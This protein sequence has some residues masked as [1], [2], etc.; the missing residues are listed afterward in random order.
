MSKI[1]CALLIVQY[2]DCEDSVVGL[3]FKTKKPFSGRVYVHGMAGDEKCSR[4]FVDNRNQSRL[5]LSFKN[6]DC[7][8]Q[9]QRLSGKIQGLLSSLIVVVSFHGTFVTKADRA[10][11]CICFFRSHKTLTN[12]IVH[13]F[14]FTDFCWM[15]VNY[16]H[17][18]GSTQYFP[19]MSPIGTTELL[20]T[21]PTPTCT[22]SI[23]TES[24][25][26]PILICTV[27]DGRGEKVD[28]ID[29]DGC[30]IDPAIQP[31]VSYADRNRVGPAHLYFI[32][33]AIYSIDAV[34][35]VFG[36]KFSDATVL[37]YEC[38]LKVCR[39]P[40]ECENLIPP[41]CDRNKTENLLSI[42]G[43]LK[44]TAEEAL[45]RPGMV[46]V[47]ATLTMEERMNMNTVTS[48]GNIPALE[49]KQHK[50]R[51]SAFSQ[52]ICIPTLGILLTA[53]LLAFTIV[54]SMFLI[55]YVARY[56]TYVVNPKQFIL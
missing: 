55:F 29:I 28:L 54:A 31:D 8:M 40:M 7:T 5:S 35:E 30:A 6:G 34:V 42:N 46:E 19:E 39:S 21:L 47:A 9:R 11:K 27:G 18:N 49:L 16:Y 23:H 33:Y 32:C 1:R 38:V 53:T 13:P 20:N 10:Y 25:D 48:G 17:P 44:F 3:T 24:P 15:R 14:K 22:Y 45:R 51:T 43:T 37:N 26:G 4:A 52:N 41:K 50:A 36:Y 2:V 12:S 56:H